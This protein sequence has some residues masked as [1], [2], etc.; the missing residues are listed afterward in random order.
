MNNTFSGHKRIEAKDKRQITK[1]WLSF[2]PEFREY[3]P[4]HLIRRN[5]AFLCGI[6]L[7]RYS[8]NIDYEPIFH[9]HNLMI[10]DDNSSSMSLGAVTNL[11]NRKGAR[12]SVTLF[13][14]KTDFYS[15]AERLKQQVSLLQKKTLGCDELVSYIKIQREHFFDYQ[16]YDFQ[17]IVLALFWCGKVAEAE[18]ELENAKKIISKWD[19]STWVI[20]HLGVE[21]WEQQVRQLMNMDTLKANV[22]MQLSK[23]KLEKFTDY[24]FE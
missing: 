23:Y 9:I 20:R 17:N 13:Q 8:G 14:H 19:E 10:D 15:Y 12:D 7:K 5:G 16:V 4:M 2:F 1:D 21:G 3:K 18:K 24:K 11:L 6:L 22:E